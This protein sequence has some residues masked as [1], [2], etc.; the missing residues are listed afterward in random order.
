MKYTLHTIVTAIAGI[1]FFFIGEIIYN[2]IIID[3]KAPLTLPIYFLVFMV[4]MIIVLWALSLKRG[5]YF[6]TR[7]KK[8]KSGNMTKTIIIT[9]VIMTISSGVLEFLYE[10]GGKI[11]PKNATSYVFVIDDSG[12]M[13]SNDSANERKNV[14]DSIMREM[15]TQLPYAVYLFNDNCQMVKQLSTSVDN[16]FALNSNGGTDIVGALK[17]VFNDYDS[18]KNVLG[19]SPKVLLL[20]D[21]ESSSLGLSRILKKYRKSI[22]T[23]STVGFGSA[24]SDYLT[25]IAEKTGGVY[26]SSN[27]IS[28]LKT[29]MEQALTSYSDGNRN[30]LSDRFCEHDALYTILR[31]LFL[32]IISVMIAIIKSSAMFDTNRQPIY[33][34]ISL[35]LGIIASILMEVMISHIYIPTKL[36]HFVCCILWAVVPAEI[37]SAKKNNG[38]RFEPANFDDDFDNDSDDY[39]YNVDQHNDDEDDKFNDL[40]F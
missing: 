34:F 6:E 31:I 19:S 1:V 28:T 15:D 3:S 29:S 7:D 40:D 32:V 5:T 39:L 33:F 30:L 20:T 9:L 10:I 2:N 24:D 27:Q 21:G 37:T 4:V 18:Q 8:K 12:S 25:N 17:T 26:I 36:V 16:N 38:K 22:I 14:I 13:Q 35:I 11:S 23:I